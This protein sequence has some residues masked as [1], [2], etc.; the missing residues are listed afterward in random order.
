MGDSQIPGD[1]EKKREKKPG[2]CDV[3]DEHDGFGSRPA[4]SYAIRSLGTAYTP[5]IAEP[6]KLMPR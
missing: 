2:W 1:Q 3:W 6:K 4:V 5:I